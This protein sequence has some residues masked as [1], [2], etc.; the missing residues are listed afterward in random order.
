[1]LNP[2]VLPPR[3]AAAAL[4]PPPTHTHSATQASGACTPASVTTQLSSQVLGLDAQVQTMA[5]NLNVL[6]PA[7]VN[8]SVRAG[9]ASACF[10]G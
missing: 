9:A 7:A 3:A 8:V 10:G 6:I 5:G 1:M 4:P 2:L